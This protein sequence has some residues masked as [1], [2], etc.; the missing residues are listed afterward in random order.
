[1]AGG[2]DVVR[3]S[4]IAVEG[5]ICTL[6][7]VRAS[8]V[9]AE[10]LVS[11]LG[12]V[13]ASQVVAEGLFGT[14]GFVR[15]SQVAVELLLSNYQVPMPQIYPT[16]IGLGYSAVKRPIWNTSVGTAAS[17]REARAGMQTYPIYEWDLTYDVLSD[18]AQGINSTYNSDLKTLMGFYNSVAGGLYSFLFTDPDDCA[19][20]GQMLGT[21]DGT[22]TNFTFVRAFGG[23]DGSTTEPVGYVNQ[24][25][26]LNIYVNG[27]LQSPTT[28]TILNATLYAQVVKF[29]TAP[30]SG[31]AIT[32][33]FSFYYGVRFKDDSYDFEKM[34]YRIWG[35]KKVTLRSVRV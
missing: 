1:M 5:L 34:M 35:L 24:S 27:T 6:G 2:G 21:G 22:T 33:D 7:F 30:A 9:V 29:T 26:T 17:G 15:V 31:A 28:Y 19:V 18:S 20:T 4:Q 8:Q 12:Y 11:T 16:L 23:G 13:R 14:L 25:Q 10:A 3:A 32:A